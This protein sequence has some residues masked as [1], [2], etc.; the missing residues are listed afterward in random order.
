MEYTESA[1]AVRV[2]F[3]FS[4]YISLKN[5]TKLQLCMFL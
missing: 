3:I 1:L 4:A 2:Y 5:L